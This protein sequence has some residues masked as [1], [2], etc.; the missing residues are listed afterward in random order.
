M[1]LKKAYIRFSCITFCTFPT[2][3][4][5]SLQKEMGS[6]TI[7]EEPIATVGQL[8]EAILYVNGVRRVLPD[9]L[10][11]ITLLQYLRGIISYNDNDYFHPCITLI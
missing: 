3:L 5:N 9:K 4:S 10:A 6:I 2:T 7:D 1:S 11:H 8:K